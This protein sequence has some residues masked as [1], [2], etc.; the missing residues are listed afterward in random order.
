MREILEQMSVPEQTPFPKPHADDGRRSAL[1]VGSDVEANVWAV[2][3][4]GDAK[5]ARCLDDLSRALRGHAE[6]VLPSIDAHA[7]LDQRLAHCLAASP[8]PGCLSRQ[9][10]GPHPVRTAFRVAQADALGEHHVGQR[11]GDR[12]ARLGVG[13]DQALDGLLPDRADDAAVV[14]HGVCHHAVVG[15]RQLQRT[16]ALLLRDQPGDAPVHLV[17]QEALG[18]HLQ[19]RQNPSQSARQRCGVVVIEGEGHAGGRLCGI[20]ERFLRHLAEDKLQ[21]QVDGDLPPIVSIGR[22]GRARVGHDHFAVTRDT[23]EECDG[24]VLALG[25]GTDRGAML[26]ADKHRVVLLVLGSPDLQHGHGLIAQDDL[27]D[28]ISGSKRLG[29]LLQHVPVPTCSLIVDAYDRVG[30]HLDASPDEAIQLVL[31]LGV[32]AL[33][34]VKVQVRALGSG[35]APFIL[36]AEAGGRGAAAHADAVRGTAALDHDHSFLRLALLRVPRIQLADACAEHDGLDPLAALAARQA[37]AEASAVPVKNRL[38]V[39]VAVVGGTIAGLD[40]DLQRLG[41]VRSVLEGGVLPRQVVPRD[42]EVAHAV[43]TDSGNRK[44]ASPRCHHIAEAPTR[45]CLRAGE[46]R[47]AARKV[48]GLRRQD[49]VD[50]RRL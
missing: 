48:V 44:G 6:A 27:P 37:H 21:G 32:A 38:S 29:D 34:G 9:L 47:N 30:G 35:I 17:H 41:E 50:E 2:V 40:A 26:L 28:V 39:L 45:A 18:A 46:R 1:K 8:H 33:D 19:K 11:L 5:L 22:L 10:R 13:I 42:A 14:E 23:P 15:H 31:H 25:D 43:R 20:H 49:R 4:R 36:G 3:V 7:D 12:E 16:H 24:A